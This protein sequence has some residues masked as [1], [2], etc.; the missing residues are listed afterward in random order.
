MGEAEEAYRAA[1]AGRTRTM[2]EEHSSTRATGGNLAYVMSRQTDRQGEAEALYQ[3]L[4]EICTRTRGANHPVSLHALVDL[5]VMFL[6]VGALD[7]AEE[8][9]RAAQER[10]RHVSGAGQVFP[11]IEWGLARLQKTRAAVAAAAAAAASHE[12]EA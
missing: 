11:R 5:A 2:G 9:Y 10:C 7:K 4:L 3:R 1:F 6:R 8:M 12:E